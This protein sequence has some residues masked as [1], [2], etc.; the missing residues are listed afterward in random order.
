[1]TTMTSTL[2]Y[3][4]DRKTYMHAHTRLH[5]CTAYTCNQSQKQLITSITHRHVCY[6]AITRRICDAIQYTLDARHS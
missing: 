1:M 2:N 5:R 6:N 4:M 3:S